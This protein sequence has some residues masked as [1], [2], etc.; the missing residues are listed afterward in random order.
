M[1]APPVD[2]CTTS[3][4]KPAAPAL[5]VRPEP[6]AVPPRSAMIHPGPG[7]R[8]ETEISRPDPRIVELFAELDVADISDQ[9]NR[10]FAPDAGIR[11]MSKPSHR[12]VGPACTVRVYPGDNLMVH[13]CLD[14]A[15][16]GDVVVIDAH[17]SSL[18][19][20]LGDM[21]STK[22]KHR[23]IA[24]FVID[25]Y[26]RDIAAIREL[27]FPIF[28]RGTTPIGPLH[29]GP[30]EINLPICCGGVVV[31][32]GDIVVADDSGVVF[33][34]QANAEDIHCKLTNYL[35]KTADYRRTLT[36]GTFS[37]TWV[38]DVLSGLGLRS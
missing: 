38:E 31:Q 28:A 33:V 2:R 23:G 14:V 17:G 29:R 24:G 27:D 8:I 25:G 34:P 36:A 6:T 21:I 20:V 9:L 32:P 15:A 10:L 22:A 30:G 12:L 26:V 13:K 5:D 1:N 4:T 7:F 35:R 3:L 37:N 18:N 11:C 16:T 19:A